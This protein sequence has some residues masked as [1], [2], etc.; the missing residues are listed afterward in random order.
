MTSLLAIYVFFDSLINVYG[1]SQVEQQRYSKLQMEGILECDTD[2]DNEGFARLGKQELLNGLLAPLPLA[3]S[4]GKSGPARKSGTSPA[5]SGRGPPLQAEGSQCS[6]PSNFSRSSAPM[7]VCQVEDEGPISAS[8][9]PASGLRPMPPS[10]RASDAGKSSPTRSQRPFT[11]KDRDPFLPAQSSMPE[12]RYDDEQPTAA[13]S[14]AGLF[15]GD[16]VSRFR[17][18]Q[19]RKLGGRASDGGDGGASSRFRGY[20]ESGG[21]GGESGLPGHPFGSSSAG[22]RLSSLSP[23]R[24]PRV[25]GPSLPG[26]SNGSMTVPSRFG[27]TPAYLRSLAPKSLEPLFGPGFMSSL[28]ENCGALSLC[29]CFSVVINYV[30]P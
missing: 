17:M 12:L 1:S 30:D 6:S 14:T 8:S 22:E 20:S 7:G 21:G 23:Q 18:L 11:L 5:A 28:G 19:A 15:G 9:P 3:L 26:A 24:D 27:Y 4:G 29:P 16:S 10:L 2:R 13:A 25:P